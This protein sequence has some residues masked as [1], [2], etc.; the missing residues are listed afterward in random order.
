MAKRAKKIE[1]NEGLSLKIVNPNAAG[2]DISSTEMQVCVPADREGENNRRF[3]CFTKDL[4][5]ISSYLQVCGIDTV[6][7]E[8]T[9]VY[10]LPLFMLVKEDGFDVI[11]VNPREIKGYSEK[12][13]DGAD[14]EWLMLL[15]SYGLLHASFQPENSARRIRNLTRH[16]EKHL[17][18]ASR[19]IQHMQKA[20]EQ[21][22]VKITNVL[23]DITGLSG[24]RMINAI[25]EGIRDPKTLA[26]L[27]H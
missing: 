17:E 6:A 25:L 8:S 7:M 3:G 15:H 2:I 18:Q 16:R 4:H 20:L 13:T 11:L 26:G 12:K 10:W 21:M 14:A 24:M 9:G 22:N 19:A 23:S 27:A 1:T 5:E